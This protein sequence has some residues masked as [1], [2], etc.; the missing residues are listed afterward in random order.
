MANYYTGMKDYLAYMQLSQAQKDE[1]KRQGDSAYQTAI[2]SGNFQTSYPIDPVTGKPL[3]PS[4]Q[5]NLDADGTMKD[6]YSMKDTL[7]RESLDQLRREANRVGPSEWANIQSGMA[8]DQVAKQNT[9]TT[10]TALTNM[11]MTG[12]SSAGSRERIASAGAQNALMQTQ[13]A[14]R[15]IASQDETNRLN[16]LNSSV[17]A[18]LSY[19]NYDKDLQQYNIGNALNDTTQKR[20]FDTNNYNEQMRAWASEKTA[21]AAPSGGKK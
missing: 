2:K 14:Y 8:A 1:A 13:N 6:V 21:A 16:A 20:L 7:N 9:G 15:N 12:G 10:A 17:N 19:G 11:A 3:R 4:W 5:S 18:E